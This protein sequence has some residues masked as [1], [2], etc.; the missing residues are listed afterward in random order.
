MKVKDLI[1]TLQSFDQDAYVY[2]NF[3]KN[4]E[5]NFIVTKSDTDNIL[6]VPE[7]KVEELSKSQEFVYIMT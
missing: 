5:D 3:D 2:M 1:Y 6:I 4:I 7:Y